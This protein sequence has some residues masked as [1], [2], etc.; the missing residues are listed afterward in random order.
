M[1]SALLISSGLAIIVAFIVNGM[2]FFG[3]FWQIL[4]LE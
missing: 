3:V 4:S 1:S 2:L